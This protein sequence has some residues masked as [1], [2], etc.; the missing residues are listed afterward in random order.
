VPYGLLVGVLLVAWGVGCALTGSRRLGRPVRETAIVVNELPFAVGYLLIASVVLALTQGDLESPGGVVVA[1]LAGL[2]LL[3]L[4]V[5][6]RRALRAHRALENPEPP[7]RPWRRILRAPLR[8]SGRNLVTVRNLPY[9]GGPHQTL[10]V[11]HRRDRPAG[12]PVVLHLHGGGFYSGNSRR[13]ARPLTSHLVHRGAVCVSAN[14]RLR[15]HATPAEQLA[16]TCTAIEWVKAHA[17][18]YGGDPSRL[19]LIGS[20]AGAYLAVEAVE[21]GVTGVAGLV[22][23]YGYYGDL[24]PRDLPPLLVIHGQNDLLVPPSGVRDFVERARSGSH[25]PVVYVE[26]PGAHHDFDL[27]ES[28]RSAAVSVAVES[29]IARGFAKGQP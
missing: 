28:I 26:L 1:G 20:S 13:E 6:V 8:T 2:D 3:G 15:P 12:V 10:D 14:Y 16:D 18:E 7:R 22:G 23:R 9:D 5:V 21:A 11:Y 25:H 24:A 19:F 17:T 27:Y 4:A 29:W